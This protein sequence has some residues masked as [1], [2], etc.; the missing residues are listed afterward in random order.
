MLKVGDTVEVVV[1]KIEPAEKRISLGLKQ[2]LGDPWTDA[3]AKFPVG[4]EVEGAVTRLMNFG[5]FVQIAEGVEGLVHI[6]E[7]VAD[8]R[9]NHPSDVV[10]VGQPVK[11]QVVAVDAE[12]RQ[13]KLSMKQLI[14]TGL[15]EYLEERKVSGDVATV[16]LGEGIR[17]TCRVVKA[18]AAVAADG[19]SGGGLDLSALSSML[20]ARW[21]TGG[22]AAGSA[23]AALEAG[24]VR[25]FTITKLDKDAKSIELKLG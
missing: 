12:K 8:R 18:A 20:N 7:M 25:S 5:A 6:S 24:Q 14:P 3:A 17:A 10:R 21:K 11:A 22:P 19:A 13:V 9:L 4:A 2:A 15:S 16:E 23:P 1:L